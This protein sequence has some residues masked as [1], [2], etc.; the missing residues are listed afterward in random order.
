MKAI[1]IRIEHNMLQ[2]LLVRFVTRQIKN[3]TRK[4]SVLV[5]AATVIID[6]VNS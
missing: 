2:A 6:E 5:D 4:S 1:I 3:T